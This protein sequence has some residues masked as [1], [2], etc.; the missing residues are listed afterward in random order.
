MPPWP[1]RRH[2]HHHRPDGGWGPQART[3]WYLRWR[4]QR[5]IFFTMASTI[6]ATGLIVGLVMS[7]SASSYKHELRRVGVF[8]GDRFAHAWDDPMERDGLAREMADDLD[9]DLRVEDASGAALG[10]FGRRACTSPTATVPVKRAGVTLG[11]V[12]ICV[13][14]HSAGPGVLWPLGIALFLLW[15]FSHRL[16]HRLAAPM[17]QLE[18]VA[19]EL[20]SGNMAA[21]VTIDRDMRFGEMPI[22]A[23]M[24]NEMAER[25]ERQLSDQRALLATVSHEI[26]TPLARM[27]LLVEF[28]R[29]GASE[30]AASSLE[31]LDQEIV[32]VDALV[33]ELLAA[34]RID[35]GALRRTTL[36]AH[37]VAQGALDRAKLPLAVLDDQAPGLTLQGDA[38]LVA[39]AVGNLLENARR[40]GGGVIKLRVMRRG[41]RI[42]FE[43]DDDGPGF[44][45][46]E[47]AQV[48]EPFYRGSGVGE[49]P[50]GSVGL[51]LALVKRIAEAHGG[52]AFAHNREG[53]GARVGVEFSIS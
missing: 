23:S 3:R 8:V 7:R 39:R 31:E 43:V 34:S 16:A 15:A 50:T 37:D 51:G 19:R 25:I 45:R 42:A 18:R 41:P 28:A 53:G 40:H 33:S 36:V 52:R 47:E 13:D 14:R 9:V 38:T 35:F 11:S 24:I 1:R 10:S 46:G 27:R 44:A 6:V 49:K 29:E 48:F 22:L 17:V 20:G 4:L 5:R 30:K 2:H 32:G 21:R 12:A 26:R